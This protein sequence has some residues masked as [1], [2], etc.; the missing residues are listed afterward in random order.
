MHSFPSSSDCGST[1]KS[2]SPSARSS[3]LASC[4]QPPPRSPPPPPPA[5]FP[6]RPAS[7]EPSASAAQG[8]TFTLRTAAATAVAR[9]TPFEAVVLLFAREISS[10][11]GE[12]PE[13][14]RPVA[15]EEDPADTTR[16]ESWCWCSNAPRFEL[17]R[18]TPPSAPPTSPPTPP[19]PPPL[20][21]SLTPLMLTRSLTPPP[22]PPLLLLPSLPPPPPAPPPVLRLPPL[23]LRPCARPFAMPLARADVGEARGE[24][25]DRCCC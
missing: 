13:K 20:M 21:P 3:T 4:P 10:R 23:L 18:P 7:C 8:S 25:C 14:R 1:H 9:P 24:D 22:P 15:T 17:R 16:G 11:A 5:G 19:P 2:T 12:E 6:T